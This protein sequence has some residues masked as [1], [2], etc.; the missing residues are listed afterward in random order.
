MIGIIDYG[1]GNLHSVEKALLTIEAPVTVSDNNEILASMDALVLPGVG[2]FGDAIDALR[3]RAFD[4][5]LINAAK[6]GKPILGVC[7]GYQLLFDESEEFGQHQ[8][9]GLIPGR[10]LRFPDNHLCVPHVGW[11]QVAKFQSHPLL[12]DIADESYF[13]F[14]HSYY[15]EL[16]DNDALIG[17]T[18][19]GLSFASIAAKGNIMGVQFHPEKSQQ[20]GLQLLKNFAFKIATK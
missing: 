11:N 3:T 17:V 6:E 12:T 5:L 2:A 19:Y 10:V 20:V 4:Q 15:V 8:G 13:Y 1:V 7:L 18:D 14:V 16:Q 9:L